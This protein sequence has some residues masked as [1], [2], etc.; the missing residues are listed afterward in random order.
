MR[1]LLAEGTRAK[2]LRQEQIGDVS[3]L[4]RQQGHCG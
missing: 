4:D 2:A 1:T 3:E